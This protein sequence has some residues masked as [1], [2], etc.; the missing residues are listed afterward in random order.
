[1]IEFFVPGLPIAGG[2]KRAFPIAGRDGKTHVAV[3][4]ASGARGTE[5]RAAVRLAARRAH[6][7][8]PLT[9]PLEVG[10]CFVLPRPRGHAGVR[11]LRPSAPAFPAIRPDVLKLARAVE[12]A[13]T[14]ILWTDDAL[15][16]SE[17][18]HKRYAD[19]GAPVGVHISV[20]P[21]AAHAADLWKGL[22]CTR[23]A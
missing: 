15:I 20:A 21:L 8:G 18:L 10:F 22:P 12:D 6:S 14:R 2:S 13:C 7:A 3:T 17:M 4:D 16:V 9:A 19:G 11:G 1:M 5:W 23:T